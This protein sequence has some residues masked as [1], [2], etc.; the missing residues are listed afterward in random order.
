MTERDADSSGFGLPALE[1]ENVQH[2]CEPPLR[3]ECPEKEM[4]LKEMNLDVPC[5]IR[6]R[7]CFEDKRFSF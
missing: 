3:E 7:G 1:R 4:F 5:R 2:Y 6:G